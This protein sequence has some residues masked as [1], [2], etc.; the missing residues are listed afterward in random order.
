MKSHVWLSHHIKGDSIEIIVRDY[1]GARLEGWKVL[2]NDQRRIK[3][4]FKII[5][6]KYGINLFFYIKRKDKDLDWLN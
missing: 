5:K 2:T 3:Q 4:V 6:N 1:S